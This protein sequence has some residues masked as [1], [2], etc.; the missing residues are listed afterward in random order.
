[1][2]R[3]AAIKV[4]NGQRLQHRR[5][6]VPFH[7]AEPPDVMGEQVVVHDAP[8]LGSEGPHD[9]IVVQVLEPG[10]VPRFA[11]LPV[12]GAL[13]RDHLRRHPQRDFPVGRSLAAGEFR[14]AVPDGDV[15]AGEPRPLGA[16]V[17]DQ[18]LVLVQLQSEGF[19]EERRQP[20]PD[21]L[22]FGPRPG[23]PEQMVVCV[24]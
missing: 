1:M 12:T 11:V 22:G 19:P 24:P 15:I 4:L 21:L 16:G 9:V 5:H 14:V 7:C 20:G 18:G 13:G 23:E 17:G 3:P 8:V 2:P 6:G 10:P